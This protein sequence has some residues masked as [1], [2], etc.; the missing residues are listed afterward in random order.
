[1]N[2]TAVS[3]LRHMFWCISVGVCLGVEFLV[4]GICIYVQAQYSLASFPK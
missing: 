3:V 2:K 4:P 1:M